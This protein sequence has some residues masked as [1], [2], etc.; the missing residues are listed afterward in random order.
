[1]KNR[2]QLVERLGQVLMVAARNSVAVGA[3]YDTNE[4]LAP[5]PAL[6]VWRGV[7]DAIV[8][9]VEAAV[10]EGREIENS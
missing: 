2:E 9:I 8:K 10:K 6:D 1:M 4:D 3:I 5:K 7:A